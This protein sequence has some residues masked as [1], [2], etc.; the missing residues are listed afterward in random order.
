MDWLETRVNNWMR[1]YDWKG[2]ELMS[3]FPHNW[4]IILDTG[5][6]YLCHYCQC[7]AKRELIYREF[8]INCI[9]RSECCTCGKFPPDEAIVTFNLL[10]E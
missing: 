10:K 6:Y 4:I 5:E 2:V 9:F 3:T 7:T 1:R 8:K